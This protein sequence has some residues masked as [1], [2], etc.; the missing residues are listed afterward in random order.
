MGLLSCKK[1]MEDAMP[2]TGD[3][4]AVAEARY[5]QVKQTNPFFKEVSLRNFEK[6]LPLQWNQAFKYNNNWYI[7]AAPSVAEDDKPFVL[8]RF[9]TFSPGSNA[10]SWDVCYFILPKGNDYMSENIVKGAYAVQ[11]YYRQVINGTPATSPYKLSVKKGKPQIDISSSAPV[12]SNCDVVVV[13][14]YWQTWENGVLVSEEY[15][16]S[17]NELSCEGGA[18]GGGT[19]TDSTK[20]PCDSVNKLALN[21][22]FRAKLDSLKLKAEATS[23]KREYGYYYIN[24]TAD[25]F[26]ETMSMGDINELSTPL[27][28]P[29]FTQVD[30]FMHNHFILYG[31]SVSIFSAADLES[32]ITIYSEEKIRDPYTFSMTL[33]TQHGDRYML[34]IEDMAQ[35]GIWAANNAGILS[36]AMSIWSPKADKEGGDYCASNEK[37]FLQY[38]SKNNTGLKFFKGNSTNNSW[39]P[40][41]YSA[42]TGEIVDDPCN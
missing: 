18:G 42:T 41:R 38:L 14:W 2:V 20:N 30:G 11:Y 31:K 34:K 25:S 24:T 10:G 39:T 4:L 1:N 9:L 40:K 23:N 6:Q 33:V 3:E 32:L 22:E 27:S 8:Y 13:D 15:L 19:S 12:P 16:F 26:E 37:S 28:I 36:R 21:A 7:P 17:T 29:A 5:R 35:F